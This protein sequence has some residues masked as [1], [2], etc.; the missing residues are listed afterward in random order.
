MTGWFKL[1]LTRITFIHRI[2]CSLFSFELWL[3]WGLSHQ[4]WAPL[5]LLGLWETHFLRRDKMSAAC[6]TMPLR[7]GKEGTLN[8]PG[9]DRRTPRT[10]LPLGGPVP[11]LTGTG[12]VRGGTTCPTGQAGPLTVSGCPHRVYYVCYCK[13]STHHYSQQHINNLQLIQ[14][15]TNEGRMLEGGGYTS[16]SCFVLFFLLYLH[17]HIVFFHIG[18]QRSE[19]WAYCPLLRGQAPTTSGLELMFWVTFHHCDIKDGAIAQ[20]ELF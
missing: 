16:L 20:T 2:K 8:H 3:D 9:H 15:Q 7:A 1:F 13:V 12:C 4:C 14:E 17:L 19:D 6:L 18:R 10:G 11:L 5:L